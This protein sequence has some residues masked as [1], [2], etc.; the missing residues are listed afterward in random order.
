VAL[1]GGS[2]GAAYP[3]GLFVAQDG[4]NAPRPQ[5]FKLVSWERIARALGL[6]R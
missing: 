2:F 1:D 6:R 3:G 5:N 4:D